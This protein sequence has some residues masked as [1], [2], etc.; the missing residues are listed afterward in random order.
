MKRNF[1]LRVLAAVA[2]SLHMAGA[3]AAPSCTNWMRQ[4]DGSNWRTCVD[5]K[6]KQYCESSKNGRI[7]RVKC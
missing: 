6:G 3:I 7:S 1:V 4:N 2:L 5:D